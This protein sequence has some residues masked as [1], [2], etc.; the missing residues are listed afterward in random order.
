MAIFMMGSG[1]TLFI[2]FSFLFDVDRAS[3]FDANFRRQSW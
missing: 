2:V 3:M 1:V